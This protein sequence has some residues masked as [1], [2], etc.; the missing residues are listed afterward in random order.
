[1]ENKTFPQSVY[2]SFADFVK[3][4]ENR[5][6]RFWVFKKFYTPYEL[7]RKF[8]DESLY[9]D[10][11]AKHGFIREAIVLPDNDIL[12]GFAELFESVDDLKEEYRSLSYLESDEALPMLYP[13]H[14]NFPNCTRLSG[15]FLKPNTCIRWAA[16]ASLCQ[17]YCRYLRSRSRGRKYG[18]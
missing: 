5:I 6:F 1:M 13:L 4:T 15:Y 7:E 11:M 3:A 2:E 18:R 8:S 14:G 17:W 16:K 10:T 9:E 12:L